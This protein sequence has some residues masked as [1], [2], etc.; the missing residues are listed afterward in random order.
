MLLSNFCRKPYVALDIDN[1]KVIPMV[2]KLTLNPA[3]E[4]PVVPSKGTP[5]NPALNAIPVFPIPAFRIKI[6]ANGR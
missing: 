1:I 3:L 4:T 2:R 5:V 6:L